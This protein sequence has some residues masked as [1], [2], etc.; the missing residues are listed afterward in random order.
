[1]SSKKQDLDELKNSPYLFARKFD[2]EIDKE[3]IDLITKEY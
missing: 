1:M 3:I 2:S